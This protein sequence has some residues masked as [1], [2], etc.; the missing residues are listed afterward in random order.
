M[1]IQS[2][3]Q[4]VEQFHLLFLDQLGQQLDKRLY[5][6]KGG[7]NLR[8]YFQSIRYSEDI[9]IDVATINKATLTN[10]VQKILNSAPFQNI[11]QVREMALQSI[12]AVKQTE[13]TQRWKVLLTSSHSKVPIHTKIEFS[14]R[15][16]DAGIELDTINKLLTQ[17]Y[18]LPPIFIPH[19]NANTAL[20][21]KLSALINRTETQA[22][23]VFDIHLLLQ[24]ANN[25]KSIMMNLSAEER[26][27]VVDSTF[28]IPYDHYVSLV[29]SY[30]DPIYS[31]QYS[32]P[33]I[34]ENMQL[35]LVAMLS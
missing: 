3:R 2:P 8:F 1:T 10:K 31:Q 24:H 19:Y 14:R 33:R 35:N 32:D 15:G 20:K 11:L 30:L 22:R 18:Q 25:A 27:R 9:D 29:V 26:Q 13:T 7:C 4:I 21:Q 6:L 16:I 5:A 34:W 12:N 23:D 17:Q 28:N